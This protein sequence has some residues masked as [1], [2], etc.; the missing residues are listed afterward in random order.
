M[1]KNINF[2]TR[3]FVIILITLQL[4]QLVF[5]NKIQSNLKKVKGNTNKGTVKWYNDE[6]DFGFI[7]PDDGSG[8]VYVHSSQIKSSGFKSLKEGQNVEFTILK[9]AKGLTATNVYVL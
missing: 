2:I 9:K 4:N 5:C 8:D 1:F 3:L 7:T 6:K